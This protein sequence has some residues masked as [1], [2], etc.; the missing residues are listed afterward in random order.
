MEYG[1]SLFN[2][3]L[4]RNSS[5]LVVTKNFKKIKTSEGIRL[6]IDLR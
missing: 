1:T 2:F 5:K 6:I 3:L 4:S